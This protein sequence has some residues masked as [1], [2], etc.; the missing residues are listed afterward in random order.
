MP[1]DRLLHALASRID[2]KDGTI[3]LPVTVRL[4]PCELVALAR[5]AKHTGKTIDELI[6]EFLEG[7]RDGRGGILETLRAYENELPRGA[8]HAK[9]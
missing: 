9:R 8:S 7:G 4:F 1:T 2:D 6:D 3:A 5:K